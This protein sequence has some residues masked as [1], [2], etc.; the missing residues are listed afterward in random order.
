MNS[1]KASAVLGAVAA[2]IA[3]AASACGTKTDATNNAPPTDMADAAGAGPTD[4]ST[5]DDE[6]AAPDVLADGGVCVGDTGKTSG[7]CLATTTACGGACGPGYLYLSVTSEGAAR[8]PIDGCVHDEDDVPMAYSATTTG[9]CCSAA[10]C[11][12][13][14]LPG[15]SCPSDYLTWTCA[16]GASPPAGCVLAPTQMGASFAPTYCCP[17]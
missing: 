9:W 10:A 16:G 4:S 11:V 1:Y 3:M 12:V 7:Y 2:F 13:D 15:G 5:L 8:P 6:S 14:G 17:P